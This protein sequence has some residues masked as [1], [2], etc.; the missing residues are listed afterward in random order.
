MDI[1]ESLLVKRRERQDH[2]RQQVFCSFSSVARIGGCAFRRFSE[3]EMRRIE[4]AAKTKAT[5]LNAMAGYSLTN[6][7]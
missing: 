4:I 3:K 2:L 1:K 6:Q 7:P 5:A